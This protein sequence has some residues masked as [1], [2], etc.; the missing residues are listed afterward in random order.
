MASKKLV[1]TYAMIKSYK[2]QPSNKWL[3][4]SEFIDNSI[5]SWQGKGDIKKSLAGLEIEIVFD[6]RDENNLKLTVSDNANGMS[7]DEILN[8]MQPSDREGKEDTHYN[9]YGVGMKLGIFWYG[10]DGI[11]HSKIKGK[12]EYC[13]ELKTSTKLDG[14]AV[15]IQSSR[16]EENFVKH[17]SGTTIRIENIYLNRKWKNN[18]LN[19]IKEALG[20][21]YGKILSR[22]LKN[23][24]YIPGIKI[25][26]MELSN[27]KKSNSLNIFHEIEASYHTPFSLKRYINSHSKKNNYDIEKFKKEWEETINKILNDPS[28]IDKNILKEFCYLLKDGKDLVSEININFDNDKSAILKFGLL[29]PS[30]NYS[31]ICGVTT[32][33]LD[34]AINHSPNSE[35]NLSSSLSFK[36]S[37]TKGGIGDPTYRR[38]FGEINLTGIENPDQN[39]S[40]FDWS[41]SGKEKINEVLKKIWDELKPLLSLIVNNWEKMTL[42]EEL[43]SKEEREEVI[44]A[45][46]KVLDKYVIEPTIQP[47]IKDGVSIN[48]PCYILKEDNKK[49]WILESLNVGSDLIK[50]ENNDEGIKIYY[51]AEHKFWKPFMNDKKLTLQYRGSCVY[52]LILLIGLCNDYFKDKELT[53]T[54]LKEELSIMDFEEVINKVVKAIEAKDD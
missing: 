45:S 43:G 22:N 35:D 9:Q 15:E 28:N 46:T 21:R 20:W 8:A 42:I 14:M 25:K 17:E 24:E 38:L 19:Y 18:D 7:E 3:T 34:R 39:K 41:Y 27:D 52:P 16:P 36:T 44:N 13:V 49:I 47:L 40:R 12:K 23:G 54:L 51:N 4:L 29:E 6:S 11:V 31:K 48:E 37:T 33:H 2:N 32:F 26:I 1:A 53:S 30:S 5:S 10:Q 50:T